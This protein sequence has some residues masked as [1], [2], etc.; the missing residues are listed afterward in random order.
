MIARKPGRMSGMSHPS[1]EGFERIDVTSGSGKKVGTAL[2]SSLS[3]LYLGPVLDDDGKKCV[4]F[5]NLW[6][7]RK[8]R[9][10]GRKTKDSNQRMAYVEAKGIQGNEKWERCSNSR[11]NFEAEEGS[12]RKEER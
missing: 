10:L 8:T 12:A 6:Q 1:I 5:E 11:F 9:S 2:A 4:R 7:F 3:P